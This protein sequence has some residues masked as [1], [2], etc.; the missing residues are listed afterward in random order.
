MLVSGGFESSRIQKA[1]KLPASQVSRSSEEKGCAKKTPEWTA[2]SEASSTQVIL[3]GPG[4]RAANGHR[5]FPWPYNGAGGLRR[6]SAV[7]PSLKSGEKTGF[8]A[9]DGRRERTLTF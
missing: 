9:S 5:S 7:S 4:R 8:K 2:G 1:V 6:P 3:G